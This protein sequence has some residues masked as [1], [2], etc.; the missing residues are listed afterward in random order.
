MPFAMECE[1]S[2][3]LDDIPWDF[4]KRLAAKAPNKL[5]GFQQASDNGVR[6]VMKDLKKM[7]DLFETKLSGE[8]W[9]IACQAFDGSKF[10]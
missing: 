7:V 8:C 3:N 4:E 5:M 2:V 1:W 10:V 9:F 6:V